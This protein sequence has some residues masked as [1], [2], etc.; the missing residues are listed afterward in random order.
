LSEVR[1]QADGLLTDIRRLVHDLRPP[2]L[3]E[4]GLIGALRNGV[5]QLNASA[6]GTMIALQVPEAM[7]PLSAA[8]EAATYRIVMEAITNVLKHANAHQCIVRLTIVEP[9]AFMELCI[10]DDGIGLP[11]PVSPGVG[12]Q[13][14]RERAEELGGTFA[15]SR[16]EP[17]GTRL[18]ARL[19]LSITDP[20]P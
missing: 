19:P 6:S 5:T 18:V 7:S 11:Q 2:A 16:C 20:Q 13:S 14:M 9:M 15:F 10:E 1:E 17:H 4:L 3:D 8:I 12:L